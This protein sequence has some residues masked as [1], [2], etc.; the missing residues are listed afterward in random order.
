MAL[1]PLSMTRVRFGAGKGETEEEMATKRS[2]ATL[3]DKDL[4]G[5]KMFRHAYP[6][7]LQDD[8]QNIIDDN[9]I[10]ASVSSIKS[11]WERVPW[12]SWTTI[13]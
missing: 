7:V 5:K 12:S 9:R 2:V 10:H 13:W 3:G 6:N 8:C 11:S 1:T 4:R